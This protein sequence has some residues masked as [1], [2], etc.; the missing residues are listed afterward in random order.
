[1]VQ[2]GLGAV[3]L[4]ALYLVFLT[5]VL[6]VGA[7]IYRDAANNNSTWAWQWATGIVILFHVG[8]VP[9]VIAVTVYAVFRNEQ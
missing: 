4:V 8:I 7:W 1:M 2:I 9:G 5:V 3:E 6:M